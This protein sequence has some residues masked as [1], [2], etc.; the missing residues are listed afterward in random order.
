MFGACISTGVA[1]DFRRVSA[2]VNVVSFS[3]MGS[4]LVY[5]E[6]HGVQVHPL[7]PICYTPMYISVYW[8]GGLRTL[9]LYFL[10][11]GHMQY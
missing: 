11:F 1:M 7:Y 9:P 2:L 8:T 10:L 4:A 6:A 5:K 3:G